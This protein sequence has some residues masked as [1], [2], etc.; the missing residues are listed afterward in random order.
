MTIG[1]PL[2]P[3]ATR[4]LML[5]SGE[6]G[7]EVAI[8]LMRLGA[9]VIACD[10]Y[11][12]APAMQ[13]AHRSHVLDMLDGDALER[14][15][16]MERP[17]LIVPEIEAIATERLVQL[18]AAGWNVVPTA[19]AAFLTMNR[20]GIR[21]L[22]AEEL[23]LATT[24]YAFADSYDELV[25]AAERIG[26]PVVI[27]PIMSS[28]GKGQSVAK[29][30]NDLRRCW[31]Y[32]QS[33]GRAGEGRIIVEGFVRFVSE[34]TLLTLRTINGTQFC[35]P[36]GHL[37]VDG[38]YVESWQ[39]HVLSP[40]QLERA[41]AIAAAVTA[42]LGGYGIFGVELFLLE[43]D[44]VLFSEVSPRPHDTGLVTIAT[45]VWSEFALHARAILGLP[46]AQIMRHSN[47]ASAAF[48]APSAC[49]APV[50][51]GLEQVLAVPGVDVR[52]FGKPESTPGRRMAVVTATGDSVEHA[53][54]KAKTGRAA[55]SMGPSRA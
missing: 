36:I 20:E 4:V 43:D 54:H 35:D 41:K 19:T 13:V 52:L 9:E 53:R 47:G 42:R 18:E 10:R 8:E 12:G 7:K 26:L 55:L 51:D 23:G 22:A 11:E 30:V 45:Q 2:T 6:L 28:S 27:K 25:Q 14:V 49:V 15:I 46:V 34:I 37:Q 3:S 24:P 17:A 29:T 40:L 32:A 33:G 31:D 16:K 21:R 38:D 1:T 48:K 5:G 44:Q 39:P 50:F